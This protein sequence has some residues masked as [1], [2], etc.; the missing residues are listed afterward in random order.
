MTGGWVRGC[1]ELIS[2]FKSSPKF[3]SHPQDPLASLAHIHLLGGHVYTAL[4]HRCEGSFWQR[5]KR[6]C[7]PPW[8]PR[9]SCF[10]HRLEELEPRGTLE[11]TSGE[12]AGNTFLG[13]ESRLSKQMLWALAFMLG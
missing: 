4:P 11:R 5:A 9:R 10:P 7:K 6:L 1:L 3:P 13:S 2:Y 8:L 12:V